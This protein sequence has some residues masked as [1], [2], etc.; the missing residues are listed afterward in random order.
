MEMIGGKSQIVLKMFF[1]F[2]F[3]FTPDLTPFTLYTE[4]GCFGIFFFY[5]RFSTNQLDDL[6]NKYE[7]AKQNKLLDTY[8]DCMDKLEQESN[9]TNGI[10]NM[11]LT[12]QE[13]YAVSVEVFLDN[14]ISN[15]TQLLQAREGGAPDVG[16]M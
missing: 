12:V 8:P 14:L 10:L 11:N 13:G 16:I 5:C 2:R 7:T 4:S 15:Y 6:S 1:I 3:F 9:D